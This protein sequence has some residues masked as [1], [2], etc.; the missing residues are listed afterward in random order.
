[1]TLTRVIVEVNLL[2]PAIRRTPNATLRVPVAIKPNIM[3]SHVC[4]SRCLH[5]NDG[6]R[7]HKLY[8]VLYAREVSN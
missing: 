2:C 1:M 4:N 6:C 7:T 8:V 3:M 5:S